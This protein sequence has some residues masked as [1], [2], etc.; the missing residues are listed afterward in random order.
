[1]LY[2]EINE[3]LLK[4]AKFYENASA[5]LSQHTDLGEDMKPALGSVITVQN[6]LVEKL[7]KAVQEPDFVFNIAFYGDELTILYKRV[8]AVTAGR[9][10]E[11]KQDVNTYLHIHQ[12]QCDQLTTIHELMASSAGFNN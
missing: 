8:L 12:A 2:Q 10:N 5:V 6:Q 1:M 3:E 9:Y 7:H 4:L 11:L